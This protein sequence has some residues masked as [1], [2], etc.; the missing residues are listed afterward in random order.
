MTRPTFDETQKRMRRM[1]R[2]GWRTDSAGKREFIVCRTHPGGGFGKTVLIITR[3]GS[4][5]L[6]VRHW[7]FVLERNLGNVLAREFAGLDP[8]P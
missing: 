5:M 8:T 7:R 1:L 3:K 4:S 6:P 2:W